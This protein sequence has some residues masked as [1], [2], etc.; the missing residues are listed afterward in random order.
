MRIFILLLFGCGAALLRQKSKLENIRKQLKERGIK[1]NAT[2]VAKKF[3]KTRR[4]IHVSGRLQNFDSFIL[5]LNFNKNVKESSESIVSF[6]K[7]LRGEESVS[8]FNTSYVEYTKEVG[9]DL[10]NSV[11]ELDPV[12]IQFLPDSPQNFEVLNKDGEFSTNYLFWMAIGCFV[13]SI[14]SFAMF[15]QYY[16]TGTTF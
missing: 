11:K 14:L 10:Y 12:S 4:I 16:K 9:K 13:F 3:E 2:V 5:K 1:T 15:F 8:D 6:N 7:A